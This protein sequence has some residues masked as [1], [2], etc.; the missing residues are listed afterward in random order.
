[1]DA[2]RRHWKVLSRE[3]VFSGGP[4]REVAVE[5]VSLP[6]GRHLTDYYQIR[7][8][9]FA[10]VFART[11]AGVLVL[12]QY[13]HGLRRV[14]LSFPGGAVQEGESPRAAA[15]REL[16]EETGHVA[17]SWQDFGPFVTN[18][19]QFCNR[20]HLFLADGCR[21]V[22]DPVD[23]DLEGSEILVVPETELQRPD[24]LS[25]FGLVS[26]VALFAIATHPGVGAWSR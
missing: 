5:H 19:N 22:S 20:A 12:R 8:D 10:L 21:P 14:C 15:E 16:L 24:I 17:E 7:M 1:M 11:D 25:E 4:I 2:N 26:H 23:P 13:K 6:N 3:S 9:D 18:A